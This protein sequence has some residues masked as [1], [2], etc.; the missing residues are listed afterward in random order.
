MPGHYV[1][2]PR[3]QTNGCFNPYRVW[4]QPEVAANAVTGPQAR[5]GDGSFTGPRSKSRSR[6]IPTAGSAERSLSHCLLHWLQAV[7][8]IYDLGDDSKD[9]QSLPH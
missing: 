4:R 6:T 8:S 7:I 9:A 5:T 1:H 2:Q 3:T